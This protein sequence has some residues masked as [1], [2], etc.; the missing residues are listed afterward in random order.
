MINLNKLAVYNSKNVGYVYFLMYRGTVVYIGET[1]NLEQRLNDHRNKVFDEVRYELFFGSD[2]A[3]RIR[4]RKAITQF[5]PMLNGQA[6]VGQDFLRIGDALFTTTDGRRCFYI[7][8]HKIYTGNKYHCGYIKNDVLVFFERN[9]IIRIDLIKDEI[10]YEDFDSANQLNPEMNWSRWEYDE[11]SHTLVN[12]KEKSINKDEYVFQYGKH[13]GK[14]M[15]EVMEGNPGYVRWF[16]K[17]VP[18]EQW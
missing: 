15:A 18:I 6:S 14:R 8:N 4:E 12:L 3:R 16:K 11:A 9:Q 5:S 1:I 17:N 13:K 7:Q 10:S 2:S